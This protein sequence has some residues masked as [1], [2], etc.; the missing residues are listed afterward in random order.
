MEKK[1]Q[2]IYLYYNLL[3][4]HDLWQAH[5][6]ILS[7]IFSKR[8]NRIKCKFGH[9]NKK[10]ETCQIKYKYCNCSIE[11]RNF[12]NT[13]IEYKCLCYNKNYQKM[14]HEKLK[15]KFFNI[16]KFSNH[17]NNKFILLLQKGVYP[18]EY[19]EGWEKFN[20]IL[21]PEKGDFYITDVEDAH[22]KSL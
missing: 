17:D 14:F 3:I 15:E 16:Y 19:K 10:C 8:I 22:T 4:L 2:K 13:L 20:E 12:K 9:N 6:Q 5:Y 18:Y 21:L 7:L 11:Y 1:L